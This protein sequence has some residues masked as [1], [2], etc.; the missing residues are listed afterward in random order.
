MYL[1]VQS[2]SHWMETTRVMAFAFLRDANQRMA[3][4]ASKAVKAAS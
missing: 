4:K 2:E 1:Y 3:R